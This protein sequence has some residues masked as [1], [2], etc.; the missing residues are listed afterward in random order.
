MDRML[1]R[2]GM[3]LVLSGATLAV[4]FAEPAPLDDGKLAQLSVG[5][6][7]GKHAPARLG[8][9]VTAVARS[10]TTTAAATARRPHEVLPLPV[11]RPRPAAAML[12]ADT[13]DQVT[14]G[15]ASFVVSGAVTPVVL[16][17]V[18]A[19]TLKAAPVVVERATKAG[20][21]AASVSVD[22]TPTGGE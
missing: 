19:V 18:K 1:Q 20:P 2:I 6:V 3:A 14:A 5:R 10:S 12:A 11:P 13:L 22:V 17:T 21:V 7:V 8:F 4:A 16:R 9:S 15:G